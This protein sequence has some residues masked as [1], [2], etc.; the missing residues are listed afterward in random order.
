MGRITADQT[1]IDTVIELSDGNPGALDVLMQLLQAGNALAMMKLDGSEVYGS[2][3]Y[4][5]YN[6]CCGRDFEKFQRMVS[7][8]PPEE[9][10]SYVV[11]K[12]YGTKYVEEA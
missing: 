4:M 5:L 6:D 10:R 8:L 12:G 9:L 7:K 1:V 11:G 2:H 3:I